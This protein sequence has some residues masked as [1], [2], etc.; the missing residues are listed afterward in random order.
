MC[1]KGTCNTEVFNAWIEQVLLSELKPGQVVIMDNAAFHES[2]KT[3]KLIES[4]GCKLIFLPPYSPDLN[5]IEKYWTNLKANIK[6]II[7]NFISLSNAI[8]HAFFYNLQSKVL[9]LK[10]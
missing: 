10:K 2:P 5:P 9:Y 7:L 4:V 8:D 3:R 1:F 6:S